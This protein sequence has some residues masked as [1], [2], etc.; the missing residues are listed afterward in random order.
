MDLE[1]KIK[2]ESTISPKSMKY[3]AGAI[4]VGTLLYFTGYAILM[5]RAYTSLLHRPTF[6]TQNSNLG[7]I[8]K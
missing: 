7:I 2:E 6:L 1:N 3:I 5:D 8:P 4:A